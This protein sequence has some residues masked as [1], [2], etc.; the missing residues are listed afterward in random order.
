ML[1]LKKIIN[2]NLYFQR[3]EKC[4]VIYVVK[5]THTAQIDF[6][7]VVA[8]LT[9]SFGMHKRKW[10]KEEKTFLISVPINDFIISAFWPL[11]FLMDNNAL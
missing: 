6:H 2:K 5:V 10:N 11:Q 8:L 1:N 3:C 7:F 9:N 4:F